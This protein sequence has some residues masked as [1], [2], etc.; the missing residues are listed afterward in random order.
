MA[1]SGITIPSDWCR[2]NDTNRM[3][4]VFGSSNTNQPNFQFLF[5]LY[6]WETSGAYTNL[7]TFLLFPNSGG[8]CE[9]NPSQVYKNFLSYNFHMS[10]N[11]EECV[12][13]AGIFSLECYE[14]WGVPPNKIVSGAWNS[15]IGYAG[16]KVYN[17]CQQFIPYDYV[18]L[19]ILGNAKW[20]MSGVT[21]GEYLTDATE[22]RGD[23]DDHMYLYF[24][25]DPYKGRPT[26]IRYTI[27]YNCDPKGDGRGPE[28]LGITKEL[29]NNPYLDQ[30][31]ANTTTEYDLNNVE[32]PP[33][34]LH[35][36]ICSAATYDTNFSYTGAY[37]LMYDVPVG[38]FQLINYSTVLAPYKNTWF[39]YKIDIL[40]GNTQLNKN[41]FYVYRNEKCGKYGKWSLYWLNPH[42]GFDNYTFDRK[43]EDKF[44][45]NRTT[46]KQKMNLTSKYNFSPYE[47]GERVFNVDV[48]EEIT[49][50]TNLLS[51]KEAQMLVQLS[52]S[53]V[54]FSKQLYQYNGANYFYATP[55]IVVSTD[56]TYPQK[57][58]DKEVSM[59]IT[60]RPANEKII[61]RN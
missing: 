54:V 57:V 9:F 36:A 58:N 28:Y 48:N 41:S 15:E 18:A 31:V 10:G 33:P 22:Y 56:I 12:D 30:A 39:Y 19:N 13:S 40:S 42:G 61:Q 60:I 49:L 27:Y 32:P 34:I 29:L 25:A 55:Y 59:E 43:N 47:A 8:T 35:P 7:G 50:R 6:K 11:L 38:P 17:G 2:V 16:R 5:E 52:Q 4:Y 44:K 23:N 3:T 51:Q 20:V 26:R 24:L 21:S 53:P 46:Y 45:I 1:I 37:T 14:Y